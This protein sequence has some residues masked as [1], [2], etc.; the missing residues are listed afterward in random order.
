[1]KWR[2]FNAALHRD[3]GY[4]CIGLTLIYAI[5]GLVVNHI[6]H[7]F[8][9]SYTIER[10]ETSV[11]P[12]AAPVRPDIDMVNRI[13]GQLQETGEF[14]NVTMI[15]PERMRIFVE[16]NTLDVWPVTGK[17]IEEKVRQ[18]PL[19][20]ELNFLHLNKSKGAWTWVAD[21]Y[22]VLLAFLAITGF[23]MIRSK[24]R[25]RGLVLTVIGFLVPLIFLII[26]Q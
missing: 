4:L 19:L 25:T 14:K 15:T 21:G 22:A 17:V 9:P 18:R 6:S 8:N 24:T 5:S 2:R 7:Q 26:S 23:L 11:Q 13:L 20:Y 16:G 1:M 3:I 10:N 12:V